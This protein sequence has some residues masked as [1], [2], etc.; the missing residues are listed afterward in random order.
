ML[1]DRTVDN[2]ILYP[3][4]KCESG[5]YY[6]I[7]RFINNWSIISHRLRFGLH[8]NLVIQRM[9]EQLNATSFQLIHLHAVLRIELHIIVGWAKL[10]GR[11]LRIICRKHIQCPLHCIHRERVARILCRTGKKCFRDILVVTV[12][13]NL[14]LYNPPFEKCNDF[15]GY[16]K[17][18]PSENDKNRR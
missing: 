5:R 13:E 16:L 11:Y 7:K 10:D 12:T 6:R 14:T 1:D 3:I 2:L 8:I 18:F 9:V 4:R 17:V 15:R